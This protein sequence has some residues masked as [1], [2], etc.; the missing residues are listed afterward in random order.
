MIIEDGPNL[1]EDMV[2]KEFSHKINCNYNSTGK[3]IGRTRA[4]NIALEKSSG[5]WMCFLDDDV[6]F[7]DHIEILVSE[8]DCKN[9]KV[10]YTWAWQA[11]TTVVEENPLKIE[12][13][14]AAKYKVHFDRILLCE[15]N[16]LPIQS[17]LFHRSVYEEAGGFDEDMD[18]LEDWNLWNRFSSVCDFH[19]IPKTTSQYR[20]PA[21]TIAKE[22]RD[23]TLA[24]AL[25]LAYEK[26]KSIKMSCTAADMRRYRHAHISK[27]HISHNV[28]FFQS[29]Q[30]QRFL[31]EI[32]LFFPMIY[33]RLRTV[34]WKMT[35]GR[36]LNKLRSALNL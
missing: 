2:K 32:T 11:N 34:G 33:T 20:V 5:D 15:K 16:Y 14:F 13:S 29:L 17:V 9:K 22:G 31:M 18:I 28:S 24:D 19:S 7:P 10:V 27:R 3:N 25:D 26:Q 12:E 36:P 8:A 6:L 21:T 35:I 4:G 30:N 23:K 1:S